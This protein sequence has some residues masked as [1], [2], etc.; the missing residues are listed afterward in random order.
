MQ[1]SVQLTIQQNQ[2]ACDTM[3]VN[4]LVDS[5]GVKFITQKVIINN[6]PRPVLCV[7]CQNCLSG[8][9]LVMDKKTD[10]KSFLSQYQKKAQRS[11]LPVSQFS[12]SYLFHFDITVNILKIC[13]LNRIPD[14]D[15][16]CS[17]NGHS[18]WEILIFK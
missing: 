18:K 7:G 15:L 1:V 9:H 4:I 8:E 6:W 12:F 3:L 2:I 10:D 11:T 17:T 13:Y 14:H 16:F 5:N